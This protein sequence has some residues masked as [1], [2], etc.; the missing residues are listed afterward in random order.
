MFGDNGSNP[1]M[2]PLVPKAV[3]FFFKSGWINGFSI[4]FRIDVWLQRQ[5]VCQ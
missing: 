5:V 3:N 4:E 2:T 1:A